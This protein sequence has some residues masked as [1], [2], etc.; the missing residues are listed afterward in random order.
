MCNKFCYATKKEAKTA[1]KNLKRSNRNIKHWYYCHVCEFYHVTRNE[2]VLI[3]EYNP[4]G[5]EL[6][7]LTNCIRT[8]T[9]ILGIDKNSK[10]T[11]FLIKKDEI[12]Y[13]VISK[14]QQLTVTAHLKEKGYNNE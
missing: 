9:N 1:I 8:H 2:R 14:N 6:E 13:V 11:Q 4:Y 3:E 7:Y 5:E 12:V 10:L